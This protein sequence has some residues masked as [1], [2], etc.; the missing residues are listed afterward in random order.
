MK[1]NEIREH[2]GATRARKRVGRGIGSGTGKTAGRGAKGQKSRSGVAIKG[3]E[4]GQ[5]PIYRRLPKR[6]FTPYQRKRYQLVHTGTLQQWVDGGRIAA[7]NIDAQVLVESG[8]ITRVRDGIRLLKRGELAR[9]ITIAVAGA[10][11]AAIAAVEAQG[12]T[13]RLPELSE[14]VKG[15]RWQRREAARARRAETRAPGDTPGAGNQE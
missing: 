5:M 3:F 11:A 1:L 13:V 4:G 15:K 14:P 6:G 10:S 9:K 8:L 2:R 12:G 7:D